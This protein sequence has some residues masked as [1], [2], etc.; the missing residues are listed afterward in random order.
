MDNFDE[1]PKFQTPRKSFS[2][3]LKQKVMNNVSSSLGRTNLTPANRAKK[4]EN[5]QNNNKFRRPSQPNFHQKVDNPLDG[6][7]FRL[8]FSGLQGELNKLKQEQ[9]AKLIDDMQQFIKEKRLT[10]SMTH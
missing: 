8:D 10:I 6:P 1:F 2:Q 3:A 9:L 4:A 5:I 7:S